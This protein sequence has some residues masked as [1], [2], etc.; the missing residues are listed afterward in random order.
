MAEYLYK[1]RGN[2]SPQ[3]KPKVFFTCHPN[4]FSR[5]FEKI[6]EDIFKSHDCA[7]YYTEDMSAE[8]EEEDKEADLNSMNLFV[9]PVTFKLLTTPNRAM[10]SDF[11]YAQ[12]MHIPVLPV[13]MET[14]IDEFYSRP[15][16][17]GERQY[18]N[19]YSNDL[20]EISYEE[21]LQKYLDDQCRF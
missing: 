1:T 17:F 12:K 13:M 5:Y 9:I 11:R 4:D 3:G 14:G 7:I 10:D 15:D 21:K 8:I 20:T 18:I 6:C 2:S 16:M 19:P